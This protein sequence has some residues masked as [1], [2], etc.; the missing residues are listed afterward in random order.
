MILEL[1]C[2]TCVG[3]SYKIMNHNEILVDTQQDGYNLKKERGIIS[4]GG[5]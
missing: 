4:L 1:K 5:M 3:Y 2:Q